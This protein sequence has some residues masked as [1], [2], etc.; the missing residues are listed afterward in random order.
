VTVAFLVTSAAVNAQPTVSP[1]NDRLE[2]ANQDAARLLNEA[3]DAQAAWWNFPGFHAEIVVRSKGRNRTGRVIVEPDGRIHL[4]HLAPHAAEFVRTHLSELV[5]HLLCKQSRYK[6]ALSQ[7]MTD[8]HPLLGKSVLRVTNG[9]D[10]TLWL[11]DKKVQMTERCHRDRKQIVQIAEHEQ[12]QDGAF[13]PKI[14]VVSEWSSGTNKIDITTT[15][16]VTW[17]RVGRF[18]VPKEIRVIA[19]HGNG[20]G[21]V[22]SSI[23]INNLTMEERP[24]LPLASKKQ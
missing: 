15:V 10:S 20:H 4:E 1:T 13:L 8:S 16:L 9:F 11:K 17:N 6:P 12:N 22:V 3:L 19:I 14:K 5:C 2:K 7:V 18:D 24:P 21:A 23:T